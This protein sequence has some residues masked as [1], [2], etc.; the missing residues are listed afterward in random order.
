MSYETDHLTRLDEAL[1]NLYGLTNLA[2]WIEERTILDGKRFSFKGHEFQRTVIN[3]AAVTSIVVK[4]AQIGLSEIMA[5]WS[6]GAACT[7][8]DFT[9][10]YTFPGSCLRIRKFCQCTSPV[11]SKA[12]MKMSERG[13]HQNEQC[14]RLPR[15]RRPLNRFF[16]I[17]FLLGAL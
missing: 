13:D 9:I 15:K 14:Q 8:D 17:M 1:A 2:K 7:Q 6:L 11:N 10:I 3:D 16:E 5:R 4:C 12:N